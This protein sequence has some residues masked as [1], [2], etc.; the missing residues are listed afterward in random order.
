[1]GQELKTRNIFWRIVLL[2]IVSLSMVT[3]T[4]N[5]CVAAPGFPAIVAHRGGTGDAPEN[6]VYAISKALQN[7]A[8][9]VWITLQLSS[10][11]VPVLY[12]PT[13]LKV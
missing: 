1:M 4:S 6:T 10:D 13:D 7:S 11:G 5:V 9:A 8:D 12:R 2:G 3:M